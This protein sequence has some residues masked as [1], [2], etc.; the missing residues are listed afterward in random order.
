M[1]ISYGGQ[2]HTLL[3]NSILES[4]KQ[5]LFS[6]IFLIDSCSNYPEMLMILDVI[7]PAPLHFFPQALPH[8][9]KEETAN[10]TAKTVTKGKPQNKYPF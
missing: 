4:K 6:K 5:T 8:Y 9:A 10:L 7:W 2:I 3:I 1:A